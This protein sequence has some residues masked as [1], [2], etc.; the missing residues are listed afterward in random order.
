MKRPSLR[1][2]ALDRK[3]LRDLWQMKGQG[4]AIAMV[5]ASGVTMYVMYLSNFD[6]LQRTRRA[7]YDHQRFADVFA[8]AKRA[9]L[10]LEERIAAV[11]GV[12]VV[13][14]RVVADVT[15]DVP[16]MEEPATGR[17]I[18][19]PATG[20][21]RLNDLF[22]RRG[23]WIEPGRDDEVLVSEAFAE[24]HG[25]GPGDHVSAIINGRKR[26][27]TIVGLA[28]SPEYI[29]I[30]PPGE[31]IPDDRRFGVFWMERRALATAFDME[32]GFNDVSLKLMRGASEED[33][34]A[35]LD[36]LLDRY[37]GRGAIPRRLQMSNWTVSNEL[38][39][40]QSFGFLIPA[41]FLGVAAFLLNVAMTRALAIQ[42]P[43]IASLKALGYG[44]RELAWHYVKWALIIAC[45][46]ALLG[47]AAGAYLGSGLSSLYN[48]FF[49][50]PVLQYRLSP[51]VAATGVL[52]S[53]VAGSLGAFF[54]VRRAVEIPPAEAMR[55][56]PPA[57]YRTSLV[58]TE[59][60]RRRLGH[61]TRMVLRNLERQPWRA[62]ASVIGIAFATG[63]LVV[64]FG[65]L[66]SMDV[67]MEAQF[68]LVQRQDVTVTF[69]EPVSAR[70]FHEVQSLPGVMYVE[71][72]RSVPAR[73]RFG[74]RYRYLGVTGVPEAPTL[75][76]VVDVGGH[77]FELPPEGLVISQV[78]AAVLGVRPGDTVL[79][80]IL[81][82]SRPVREIP[83][84]RTVDDYMGV[85]VYMPMDAL[86]RLMREGRALSGAYLQADS[87]HLDAL[88]RRLKAMPAVGGVAIT[89]MA[90]QSFRKLMAQNFDIMT[91][92]NVLFAGIIAFGVVYNAARIS[93]SERSRELA[94]LRVLGFTILE[95]SLILLGELS[96]LT[97]LALPLG[98]LIGWGLSAAIVST[99]QSEVYRIPLA[100]TPQTMA[101]S[102]LT[103][104][105]AAALSGLAVRRKLDHLDLVAVLKTR[106]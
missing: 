7:Y 37:G 77:V 90:L 44:N 72:K 40:L 105:V 28:L 26:A 78:L 52:L 99:L 87:D 70:A 51:G 27:L 3:L 38:A 76:R 22:L 58:E 69:V 46:G 86:H 24:A 96:I 34:I 103:V 55:P 36:R 68:N 18:S 10:R 54:A 8:S 48:Q 49:R 93:L 33:V 43:Q 30:I 57:R 61:A 6:S 74:P 88:Y 97:V 50:F 106:E 82:G 66:D 45:L 100:I 9:P 67:L 56:E 75:N 13:D 60:V 41:I 53:L 73:V 102:A 31:L 63:I 95:I 80:E 35:R 29:Y 89:A 4:L 21:P 101:W 81:E 5:V 2:P 91:I 92:G 64:G 84:A 19:A 11:P 104:I 47:I 62:A 42:R 15:L 20:R 85:A 14:L 17:L 25:L 98:V 59:A 71:P 12:A 79:L 1:L 83:V 23:R 39:Q 32:G 65:F 16:G 94:S